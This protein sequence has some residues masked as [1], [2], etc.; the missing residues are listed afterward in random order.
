MNYYFLQNF[1]V[2][3]GVD[4]FLNAW[5]SGSYPGGRSFNVGTDVF[6]GGGF[7]FTDD[8]LKTLLGSGAA[9]AMPSSK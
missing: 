4:D 2:T 8:D 6:F 1:Y 3:T 5:R 7:Y 9:S